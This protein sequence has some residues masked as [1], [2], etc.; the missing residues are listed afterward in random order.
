MTK[1]ELLAEIVLRVG[2][3]KKE[4]E[5]ATKRGD[6]CSEMVWENTISIYTEIYHMVRK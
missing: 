6:N 2:K 1:S 4:L 3:A 5:I